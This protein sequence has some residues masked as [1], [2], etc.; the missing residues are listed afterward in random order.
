MLY[1]AYGSNMSVKRLNDRKIHT[2]KVGIGELRDYKLVCNKKS[3]DQSL[4]FNIESSKGSQVYGVMYRVPESDMPKLDEFEGALHGDKHYIRE[5]MTIIY[6]GEEQQ[7]A[8]Y[9]CTCTENID[10]SGKNKPYSWYVH[11]ALIGACEAGIDHDYIKKYINIASKEDQ[12]KSR[13]SR[14]LKIYSRP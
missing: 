14:E 3:M 6:N 10:N 7:A 8:T 12:N 1:F 9:I 11:H 2:D 13:A 4:K 5:M